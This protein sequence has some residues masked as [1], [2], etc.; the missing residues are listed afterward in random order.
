MND[1]RR[2]IYT[3]SVAYIH[4][5]YLTETRASFVLILMRTQTFVDQKTIT[6]NE[7]PTAKS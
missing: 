4:A 2:T 7:N 1:C 5:Q 3:Y 6:I